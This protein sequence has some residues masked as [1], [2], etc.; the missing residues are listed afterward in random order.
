MPASE[1]QI[2]I[3][4]TVDSKRAAQIQVTS[5]VD[6]NPSKGTLSHVIL[7]AAEWSRLLPPRLFAIRQNIIRS[8]PLAVLLVGKGNTPNLIIIGIRIS[9]TRIKDHD[10]RFPSGRRRHLRSRQHHIRPI[11]KGNDLS[12]IVSPRRF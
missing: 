6:G 1:E 5:A 8:I 9:S 7:V 10:I 4:G 11:P 2:P 3:N 12:L